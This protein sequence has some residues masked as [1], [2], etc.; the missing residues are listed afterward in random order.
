MKNIINILA[1]LKLNCQNNTSKFIIK[2]G[3][4][5]RSLLVL[6]ENYGCIN[7][8][9][10]YSKNQFIIYLRTQSHY[11]YRIEICY[12]HHQNFLKPYKSLN[13]LDYKG[14][15]WLILEYNTLKIIL[16]KQYKLGEIIAKFY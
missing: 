16:P 1:L 6:L 3:K 11:M 14:Q 9:S 5:V 13:K 2:D 8:Y 15:L 12:K 10:Y 7:Y 4:Y